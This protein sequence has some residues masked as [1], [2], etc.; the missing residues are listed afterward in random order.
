MHQRPFANLRQNGLWL[1]T[2]LLA[3]S[4][5][6]ACSS[7]SSLYTPS[8]ETLDTGTFD[9][10]EQYQSQVRSH[11]ERNLV[12]VDGFPRAQQIAWNLPFR[13]PVATHCSNNST[14]GLLLVHGLSDSPF[15]FRDLANSLADRCVEVRTLLLQ[16][17]GTRPGDMITASA[18]VWRQQVRTHFAALAQDVD[19]A[20]IGGFSLGGALATEYALT[21]QGPEPEG[22]VAL[23]PAWQLNGLRNY[24]WLAGIAR[25]FADFVEEEPELNPVKYESVTFNAAVQIGNVLRQTQAAID[26]A[27]PADLPLY[28]IATEADSVI[29]LDYLIQRFQQDFRHPASRLLVFRDTRS[30]WPSSMRDERMAEL[31]SYLPEANILEMSHQSL[32]IAPD[33]ELYG[34]GAPLQRCL[35]PNGLSLNACRQLPETDLWYSAWHDGAQA[36]PTSRLT[37]NP[38]YEQMVASLGDFLGTPEP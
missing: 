19:R 15:V 12:A 5:I 14:T 38:W 6:T 2:S 1:L 10:F 35:E 24:L 11:L 29:N 28:L 36:V 3:M 4:V 21:G 23:A 34:L 33:N 20:Y 25:V 8:A 26:Q 30:P 9:T 27:Q 32:A 17:H 18:D 16:G 37:Y 13:V 22:L 7:K 31:N